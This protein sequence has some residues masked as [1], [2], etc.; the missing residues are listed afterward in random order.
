MSPVPQEKRKYNKI[1]GK[2]TFIKRP[3]NL[4]PLGHWRMVKGYSHY[5]VSMFGQIYSLVP[6]RNKMISPV[7][8]SNGYRQLDLCEN[9]IRIKHLLHRVVA[10]AFIPN[11]YGKPFINHKDCNPSNCA[12]YNIHWCTQEENQRYAL[13]HGNRKIGGDM[14]NAKPVV[15]LTIDGDFVAE[16][17]CIAEAAKQTGV[18]RSTIQTSCNNKYPKAWRH[19]FVFLEDYR[20]SILNNIKN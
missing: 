11:L 7:K 4:S 17:N 6:K 5:M 9:S 19:N 3:P 1:V 10:T 18:N 20:K 16:F 14:V 12:T 15:R 13:T 2:W 8:M